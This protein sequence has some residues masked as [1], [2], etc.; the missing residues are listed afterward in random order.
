MKTMLDALDMLDTHVAKGE[1]KVAIP[2]TTLELPG[3]LFHK[4][5]LIVVVRS[6]LA[7]IEPSF[8]ED[9]AVA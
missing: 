5:K 9:G 7:I 4:D 6:V 2:A 1:G 8:F 3:I